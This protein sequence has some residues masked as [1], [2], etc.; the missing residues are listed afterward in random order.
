MASIECHR[1]VGPSRT[2]SRPLAANG[3]ADADQIEVGERLRVDRKA[4][5]AA[6]P[7][8]RSGERSAS[9]PRPKPTR[10]RSPVEEP[11]ALIDDH[12]SDVVVEYLV[13][14]VRLRGY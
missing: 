6:R 7:K 12:M 5:P 2:S 8:P 4:R 13:V 11:D 14:L 9:K 3:I 1:R 10:K